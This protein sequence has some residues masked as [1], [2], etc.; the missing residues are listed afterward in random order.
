[1]EYHGIGKILRIKQ[2]NKLR[3][4]DYNVRGSTGKVV[5]K[6]NGGC[7]FFYKKTSFNICTSDNSH[8]YGKIYKETED[9]EKKYRRRA[10][11]AID[12][13]VYRIRFPIDISMVSKALIL[14]TAL[15]VVRTCNIR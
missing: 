5:L 12:D 4:P 8:C 6:V 10:D 11:M 3:G 9:E 2:G 7:C 15:V 14:A 13:T 1:L